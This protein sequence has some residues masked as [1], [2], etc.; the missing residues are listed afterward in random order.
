[1]G[2]VTDW[3]CRTGNQADPCTLLEHVRMKG[4]QCDRRRSAIA[5]CPELGTCTRRIRQ[6]D[7]EKSLVP[8][9]VAPESH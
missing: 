7:N 5:Q 6:M 2:L 8:V 1:M 4:A 9:R 3:L